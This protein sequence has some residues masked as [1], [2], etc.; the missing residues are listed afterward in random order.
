MKNVGH[1]GHG[2]IYSVVKIVDYYDCQ[3]FLDTVLQVTLVDINL[4]NSKIYDE[5]LS[6]K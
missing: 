4:C 6:E 3:F 1:D 2:N 5:I